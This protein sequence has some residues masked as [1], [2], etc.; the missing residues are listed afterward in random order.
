MPQ[1][2]KY[3]QYLAKIALLVIKDDKCYKDI[4]QIKKDKMF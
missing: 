3:K 4:R 1:I 2:S